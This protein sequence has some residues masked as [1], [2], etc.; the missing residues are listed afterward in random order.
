MNGQMLDT[1]IISYAYKGLESQIVG[2][3]IASVTAKE[4]LLAQEDERNKVAYYLPVTSY[5]IVEVREDLPFPKF[6][7]PFSKRHTDQIILEL[8]SDFPTIVQHGNLA[9]ASIINSKARRLYSECVRF[10]EKEK[11]KLL[12]EKFD[13]LID[14]NISC[15]PLNRNSTALGIQ[16]FYDF[17]TKFNT[18]QNIRNTVNDVLI[19]ATAVESS[20]TLI[21]QDSVLNRFAAK[22]FD[23]PIKE[24]NNQSISIGFSK[25]SN[26]SKA[27]HQESKGYVNSSWRIITKNY[28]VKR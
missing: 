17:I 3:G 2:Q 6:E 7:H 25:P 9:I 26:L 22:Y 1:Q 13:F 16:L 19:L 10:L 15:I 14:N 27:V 11:R 4:F 18:K 21:S 8:G 28:H 5:F 12:L 23:V 20:T 24:T